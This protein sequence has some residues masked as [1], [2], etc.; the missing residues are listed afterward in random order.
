MVA[1]DCVL[2]LLAEGMAGGEMKK[3]RMERCCCFLLEVK[4]VLPAAP[5]VTASRSY[6]HTHM[7]LQG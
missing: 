4:T 2:S 6:M 7:I 1:C 5:P 3:S